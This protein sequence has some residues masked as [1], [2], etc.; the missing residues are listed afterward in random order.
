M[1]E[2]A[3]VTLTIHLG[4]LSSSSVLDLQ[5]RYR[6]PPACLCIL[7]RDLITTLC[8]GV[9]ITCFTETNH[10]QLLLN[11][12]KKKILFFFKYFYLRSVSYNTGSIICVQC[13][14]ESPEEGSRSG[15][16][17]ITQF[18]SRLLTTSDTFM[19]SFLV[20]VY[21]LANYREIHAFPRQV[22]MI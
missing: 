18:W 15:L 17:L 16:I 10:L 22:P 7:P 12:R 14:L 2:C 19:V 11:A 21:F 3:W 20:E 9:S 13:S 1:L 5:R 6:P 4:H 8:I